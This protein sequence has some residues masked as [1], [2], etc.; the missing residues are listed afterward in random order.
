MAAQSCWMA[1]QL[2]LISESVA[3]E[4][5]ATLLALSAIGGTL[6]GIVG[7]IVGLFFGIVGIF[8]GPIIGALAG[9]FIAGKRLIDAGRAGWGTLLGNVGGM[10]SK[11]AIGLV[12]I[13]IFEASVRAPF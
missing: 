2:T 8:V 9:E 6:G 4:N 7:A 11:L 12:M 5:V 1:N 3:R 13:L 10:L